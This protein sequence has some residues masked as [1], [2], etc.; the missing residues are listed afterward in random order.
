MVPLV[1][2]RQLMYAGELSGL[3]T[4]GFDA[5]RFRLLWTPGYMSASPVCTSQR[6][7]K[8]LSQHDSLRPSPVFDSLVQIADLEKRSRD[9]LKLH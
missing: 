5:G 9:V 6:T 3:L 8:T 1:S 4:P 2:A 7:D